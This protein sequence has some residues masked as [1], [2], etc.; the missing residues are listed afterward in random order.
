MG[1]IEAIIQLMTL[2]VRLLVAVAALAS[3]WPRARH[4][5]KR[6]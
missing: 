1:I 5:R 3:T 6:R 2:V 4:K